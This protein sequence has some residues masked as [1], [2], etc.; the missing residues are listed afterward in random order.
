MTTRTVL[1]TGAGSGFGKGAAVELAA[2]GHRVIAT[3]ETQEQADALAAECSDL[4]TRKLDVTS[5]A[6][7]SAIADL[8]IDVLINNAG[9]GV[10][11]PLESVPM[12]R[13]RASFDVNVFAMVEMSQ[14]VIPGMKARGWGRIINVSSVAGKMA[15]A[16]GSPYCMTKH[17]VEAF[18]SSLRAEMQPFGIDVTKVNPGPYDTGFNDRMVNGIASW[19]APGDTATTEAHGAISEI[20]LTGQLDPAEVATTL[21]DLT[22]AESTPPETLLPEGIGELLA[23]ALDAAG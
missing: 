9:L 20:V 18:T 6:D 13:V 4:E 15:G 5:S 12:E 19:I 7:I 3:T 11:A 10:M 1:I 23:A 8:E 16:L 2:R 17:A 22:E 14:A 21:A